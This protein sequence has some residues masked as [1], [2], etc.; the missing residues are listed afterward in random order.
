V[1]VFAKSPACAEPIPQ[2]PVIEN[3]QPGRIALPDFLAGSPADAEP[4]RAISQI[5][6]ADLKRSGVVV[7]IDHA[8]FI[9]KIVNI[10]ASPQ[11]ADWRAIKAEELVT[12]RVTS[13]AD[14]RIKVEF[15]LWDVFRGAQLAGQ[16]YLSTP[17][18]LRRMAHM[19][20]DVIYERLTGR[21]GNFGSGAP[22]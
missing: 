7:P 17:D 21:K 5:I 4:A 12:G 13:Q 2:H 22:P 16:Q 9:E 14:A 11:F 20:S 1:A 8:M 6:A 15:R 3:F 18:D 19:I 10:D